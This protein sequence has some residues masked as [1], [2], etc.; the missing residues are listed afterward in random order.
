VD[1]PAVIVVAEAPPP[2]L[3]GALG[4]EGVA[5]LE[6]ALLGAAVAWGRTVGEVE[7]VPRDER[8]SALGRAAPP[9]VAVTTDMPTLGPF[10][11]DA[12]RADLDAGVDAV[13]GPAHDG[14]C[15][16]LALGSAQPGLAALAAEAW[17][18]PDALARLLGRAAELGLEGGLLRGERRL[19]TPGDARALLLHQALPASVAAVLRAQL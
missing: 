8:A 6:G 11:A 7:V 2:A 17:N 14:G 18:E 13:F 16:L 3:A 9:V 5:R 10:H 19:R 1:P 15:Y 12:L 4:P